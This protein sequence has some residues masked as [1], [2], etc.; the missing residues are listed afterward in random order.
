MWLNILLISCAKY[1]NPFVAIKKLKLLSKLKNAY[2][3]ENKLL[4]YALADGR[5][6]FSYAA[7]G[8]PSKASFLPNILQSCKMAVMV[9]IPPITQ[10]KV[11]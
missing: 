3:G 5:F 1:K 8:W 6:Y 2:R 10:C 9:K 7:P 4:K 11:F